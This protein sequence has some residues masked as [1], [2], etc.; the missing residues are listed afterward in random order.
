MA[1]GLPCAK[2]LFAELLGVD[3]NC[4]I[5]GNSSSLNMIYDMIARSMCFGIGGQAPWQKQGKVKFICV[6][7]GYDRHFAICELFGIEMVPVK[8]LKTGP[9][10]DAVEELVKDPAV[11]GILC[12]PKYSNP[13]GDVFGRYCQALC[14]AE[15]RRAGFRIYWDNA[16]CIHDHYEKGDELLNIMDEVK[17]T[18]NENLVFKFTS[19]SKISFRARALRAWRPIRVILNISKAPGGS[20]DLPGQDKPAAPCEVL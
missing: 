8:M 3:E 10:M 16:Y 1:D 13:D 7:P 9:D 6:V 19:T 15:A 2:R 18:G 17:K 20:D 11:K 14:G 4:V 5:V 12:I